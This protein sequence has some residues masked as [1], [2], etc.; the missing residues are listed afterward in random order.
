LKRIVEILESGYLDGSA[1]V[2]ANGTVTSYLAG[3]STLQVLYQDFDCSTPHLNPLTLSA[4]GR[5]TAYT[6][7]RVKL[8]FKTAAGATVRTVDNVGTADIDVTG[9]TTSNIAGDGLVQAV[10]GTLAVNPDGVTLE[11]ST[12]A[13]RIK[14]G[15]LSADAPGRAK[16]ADAFVTAAKLAADLI[17]SREIMNAAIACSASANALTISLKTNAGNDPSSTDSMRIG[18]RSATS[19]SGVYTRRTITSAIT[20]LVISSGSTLGHASGTAEPVYVYAL[21]NAGTVELAVSTRLFDEGS[22]VSTT[23]E[24]GSGAADS[25]TVMYSTSVRSNVACRLIARLISNQVTAGTWASGPSEIAMWNS[26]IARSVQIGPTGPI[27]AKKAGASATA[28]QQ[29]ND[30]TLSDPLVVSAD[31]GSTS[32]G[33][34]IVRGVIAND[35]SIIR[36]EGFTAAH[37]ATGRFTITF[38]TA[39]SA[40]PVVV[41]TR[42]NS[43]GLS[44][45]TVFIEINSNLTSASAVQVMTSSGGSL[46]DAGFRFIAIGPR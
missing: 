17:D 26:A 45:T 6:N 28:Y 10:D 9:S 20:S 2:L 8:V 25:R 29:K 24:G 44:P 30:G 40:E 23:A 15:A 1:G 33:L 39:F 35:G 4:E 12:D 42:D 32:E 27:L 22:V 34:K 41:C 31:T 38:T 13:L 36:G 3:T 7:T 18:F 19:S 37:T 43:A 14:D 46:S 11:I 16:M 21:D 5:V